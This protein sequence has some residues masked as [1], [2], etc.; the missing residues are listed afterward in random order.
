[1][2]ILAEGRYMDH[3]PQNTE[4]KTITLIPL[5]NFHAGNTSEKWKK[6]HKLVSAWVWESECGPETEGDSC[7]YCVVKLS[8]LDRKQFCCFAGV[9]KIT[10]ELEKQTNYPSIL[11][12]FPVL[13]NARH[14][15]QRQL[16]PQYFPRG[17]LQLQFTCLALCIGNQIIIVLHFILCPSN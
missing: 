16:L 1:M 10:D 14:F 6:S 11:Y 15:W 2:R 5:G 9:S 4:L 13:A 7:S 3:I 12:P 8:S 17:R